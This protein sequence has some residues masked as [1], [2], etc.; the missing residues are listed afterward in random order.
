MEGEIIKIKCPQCGTLLS[1]KPFEGIQS[2]K[3]T[4]PVC[5]YTGLFTTFRL[6]APAQQPVDHTQYHAYNAGGQDS[7]NEARNDQPGQLRVVPTG[8]TFKLRLGRNVV[9]RKAATSNADIQL[10]T[11]D[12]KRMSREHIVIDVKKVPQ[13]GLVPYISLYKEKVNATG[14]NG[15]ELLYG[16]TIV[17]KDGDV[18]ELPDLKVKFEIPDEDAT[19]FSEQ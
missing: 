4:C 13:K 1:V 15:E 18:I 16:D 7:P 8:Q 14:V 19:S 6:Q 9:G 17:L 2:K 12:S 5:K 11:G 10:P 3:V